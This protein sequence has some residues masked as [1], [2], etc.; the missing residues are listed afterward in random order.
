MTV[1]TQIRE[2]DRHWAWKFAL[3]VALVVFCIIPI[4]MM[5]WLLA[6]PNLARDST[7]GYGAGF[8]FIPLGLAIIWAVVDVGVLFG[9]KR[10]AHPGFS[11]GFDLVLFIAF[12][13]AGAAFASLAIITLQDVA[14]YSDSSSSTSYYGYDYYSGSTP[15]GSDGYSGYGN[16]TIAYDIQNNLPYTYVSTSDTS[17]IR[18]PGDADYNCPDWD[19]CADQA[20]STSLLR[21][22]LNV[23][24]AAAIFLCIDALIEFVLFVWGCVDCHAYN[25]NA[26]YNHRARDLAEKMISDMR[27]KAPQPGDGVQAGQLVY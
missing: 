8:F 21:R 4:G 11:V 15:V 6:S 10:P 26:V 7:I 1:L 13:I 12:A 16:S 18:H 24:L 23:A 9:R 17:S 3:R 27:E 2:A 22:T 25:R 19:S 14:Y 5:I 20:A